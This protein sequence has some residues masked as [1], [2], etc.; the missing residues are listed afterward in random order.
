MSPNVYY[1]LL[2]MPTSALMPALIVPTCA[3]LVYFVL[4]AG[5]WSAALV[6]GATKIAMVAW[7]LYATWRWQAPLAQPRRYSLRRIT[8]EGLGLGVLMGGAILVAA[9]G[10]L[11][12]LLDAARPQIAEK[13][14]EFSLTTPIAYIT[15]ALGISLFHSAFEEWYWR[16]FVVGHL[17]ARL[18][19]ITAHLIGGLAFA[20]HHI[21]VLWV[22]AG[23]LA[24][25]ALGLVVGGAGVCWSLLRQR[26]GS[27]VGAWI[28]H[29]V[30]DI[31]I[32]NLGWWA[33]H[34]IVS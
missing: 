14:S 29:M 32:M 2:M 20:G 33:L 24:G 1:R 12:W 15:M 21:V 26:H 6:Y 31:A 16:W 9:L 30:C 25:V 4:A 18:R 3:A 17:R 27:L 28:A 5:H 10:P 22:Y 11:A 23:P 13:I 19:P 7:P 34:S 8:G